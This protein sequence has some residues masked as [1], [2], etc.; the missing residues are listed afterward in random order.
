MAENEV[1]ALSAWAGLI[2]MLLAALLF[3]TPL[4]SEEKEKH[5]D[6]SKEPLVFQSDNANSQTAIDSTRHQDSLISGTHDI[7]SDPVP[8]F[9]M[10]AKVQELTNEM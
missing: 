9:K 7:D 10:L 8:N 1:F 5:D 3:W 2:I 6:G 4:T